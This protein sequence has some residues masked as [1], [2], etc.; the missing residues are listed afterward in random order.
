M[1]IGVKHQGAEA[2]VEDAIIDI[3]QEAGRK[4]G[5]QGGDAQPEA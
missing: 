2:A 1:R 3:Q 4:G 5:A